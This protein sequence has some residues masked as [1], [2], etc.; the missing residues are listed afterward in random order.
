MYKN[1][2]PHCCSWYALHII[3]T[4]LSRLHTTFFLPKLANL[5]PFLFDCS[6]FDILSM[7]LSISL[8]KL[9]ELDLY[10]FLRLVHAAF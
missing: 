4:I 3:E 7:H 2:H 10:S 8:T 5:K 1:P 6:C 9:E